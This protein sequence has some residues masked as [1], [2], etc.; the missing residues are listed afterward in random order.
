MP[1]FTQGFVFAAG[2][3]V[4]LGAGEFPL[5]PLVGGLLL[6]LDRVALF[7]GHVAGSDRSKIEERPHF[8][9]DAERTGDLVSAAAPAFADLLDYDV[10]AIVIAQLRQEIEGAIPHFFNACFAQR[11]LIEQFAQNVPP[12][13]IV[14]QAGA[15]HVIY[16]F[17]NF[18]LSNICGRCGPAALAAVA[19]GSGPVTIVADDEV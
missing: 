12:I 15:E 1:N 10:K 17:V 14:R 16:D 9:G 8:I 3:R 13:I 19:A 4:R 7:L 6:P 5:P 2:L 18:A 11:H